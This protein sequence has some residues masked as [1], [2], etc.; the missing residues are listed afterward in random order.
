MSLQ[1]KLS[2][3]AAEFA[4]PGAV[5]G[6][7]HGDRVDVA[8][9]GVTNVDHPLPVTEETLFQFGS[10]GKTF[11]AT[12]LMVL[13]QQGLVDLDAP[14]RTY[15]PD[16]ALRDEDAAAKVTVLQLLNHTAG[17][18]GDSIPDTGDG[19][20]CL[21]RFVAGMVDLDQVSPLGSAVSYNN[22]SLVL[23]GHLIA[24]VTG[25]T[26]EAAVRSLVLEP[27]GLEHT[28]GFAKEIMT[29]RYVSGHTRSPE[30]ETSIATPWGLPRAGAPAGGWTA[31]VGDQVAWA[32]F[33]L[34]LT[35]SDL[36]TDDNRLR[37]QQPTVEM[38]GNA[39]GDAVGISWLLKEHGGVQLVSHGGTMIGQLSDFVLVPEHDFGFVCM[40]NSSPGGAQLYH[41]LRSWALD[42]YLSVVEAEPVLAELSPGDLAEFAGTYDTSVAFATITPR[43]DVL[44][45]VI[46][47][48][49]LTLMA[50]G[51]PAEQPAIHIGLIDG[52]GDRYVVTDGEAK[53]MR[54]YFFRGDDGAVAGINLGGRDMTR[55]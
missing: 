52:D 48:T 31:A 2:E 16:L 5:V 18:A 22:A 11:T 38:P 17:W 44:D 12:A 26:Y 35:N 10:T 8:V 20:D 7:V 45:V 55:R 33:H 49:D 34:G 30:G 1:E 40:T 27:L 24:T 42:E 21:V 36:L 47:I 4:V 54:G 41:E 46:T 32:Q 50:E 28:F 14:V 51:D 23:A 15:L 53:G 13:V 43:D 25:Q 19:D 6:V 37:M 3:L 39:L 9:H 29:K